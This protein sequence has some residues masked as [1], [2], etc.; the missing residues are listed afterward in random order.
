MLEALNLG[1]APS[2]GINKSIPQ[3]QPMIEK[4]DLQEFFQLFE[5]TQ[6]ARHTPKEAYA[7]PL[8]PQLNPFGSQST[9]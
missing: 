1:R 7:A 9:S 2:G 3:V 6:Q 5:P 8:L 4:E